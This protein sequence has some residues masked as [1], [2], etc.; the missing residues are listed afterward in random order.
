MPII[1]F[2]I[3]DDAYCRLKEAANKDNRSMSNYI[4]T[5]VLKEV[6][7]VEEDTKKTKVG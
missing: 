5:L 7:P 2:N 1:S 4:D 3:S 6:P